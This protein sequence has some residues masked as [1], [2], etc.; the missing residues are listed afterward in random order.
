MQ[1]SS[2]SPSATNIEYNEKEKTLQNAATQ[3][4]FSLSKKQLM[5]LA[6]LRIFISYLSLEQDKLTKDKLILLHMHTSVRMGESKSED[7]NIIQLR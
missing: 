3:H 4:I 6:A 1:Y 5:L 7:K 2:H